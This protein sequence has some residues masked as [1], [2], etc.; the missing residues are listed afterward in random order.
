MNTN[1]ILLLPVNEL[2]GITFEIGNY[3]RGYKWG[4]KEILELLNDIYE[5]KADSG[6]YCLQPLIL[7]PTAIDT[8]NTNRCRNYRSLRKE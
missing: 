3:Q 2:Q 8:K 4:K 6:L 7:K 5:Y 1:T